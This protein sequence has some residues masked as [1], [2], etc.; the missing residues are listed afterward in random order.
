MNKNSGIWD[1]VMGEDKA[2]DGTEEPAPEAL[3][4]KA[5]ARKRTPRPRTKPAETPPPTPIA[6]PSSIRELITNVQS[7][8][9][10]A[11]AQMA[12]RIGTARLATLENY[13][14]L[15]AQQRQFL[16][17][18]ALCES[19]REACR[20]IGITEKVLTSWQTS[21]VFCRAYGGLFV[22][23][24][25]FSVAMMDV[26]L[27]KG[28]NVIEKALDST[29]LRIALKGAELLMKSKGLLKPD[30]ND[31]DDDEHLRQLARRLQRQGKPVPLPLQKYVIEG[32]YS[33]VS[34][35]G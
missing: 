23:P 28:M 6:N 13:A 26:L 11:E 2:G 33:V 22:D 19:D 32:D 3:A 14:G 31:D 24:L 8:G 7:R 15:S 1:Q 20:S 30:T 17:T 25:S 21:A 10:V 5:P 35:A 4:R 27:P 16:Y 9:P 29:N 18:R 34:E 12:A